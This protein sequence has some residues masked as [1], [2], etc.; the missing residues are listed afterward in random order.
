MTRIGRGVPTTP[1]QEKKQRRWFGIKPEFVIG[2][3]VVIAVAMM[4]MVVWVFDGPDAEPAPE[5]AFMIAGTVLVSGS[6]SNLAFGN[7]VAECRGKAGYEDLHEGAKVVVADSTGKTIAIGQLGTGKSETVGGSS[8]G[9][10]V[11]LV[12]C[13]FPIEV[14]DVPDGGKFYRVTVTHRGAQEYTRDQLR[15]PIS[16]TLG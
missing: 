3:A 7:S 15:E 4:V 8:S 9:S 16:L 14:R 10:V 12:A 2:A 1:A 11:R 6:S 13:R 5:G